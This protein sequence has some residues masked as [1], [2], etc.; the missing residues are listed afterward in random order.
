MQSVT[1]HGLR[2]ARHRR[3]PERRSARARQVGERVER[4]LMSA[5][6]VAD[7]AHFKSAREDGVAAEAITAGVSAVTPMLRTYRWSAARRDC[8]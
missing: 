2:N 6:C 3:V 8:R 4:G 1:V 7:C 5:P